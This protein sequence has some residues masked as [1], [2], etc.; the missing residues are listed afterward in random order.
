LISINGKD[1]AKQPY[2]CP[3]KEETQ[4]ASPRPSGLAYKQAQKKQGKPDCRVIEACND[5]M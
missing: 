5:D 2:R 3:T 4:I 1:A